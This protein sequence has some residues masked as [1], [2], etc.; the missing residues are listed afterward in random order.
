MRWYK[1]LASGF[2]LIY[3]PESL[4]DAVISRIGNADFTLDEITDDP[5]FVDYPGMCLVD[6]KTW[7]AKLSSGHVIEMPITDFHSFLH[8]VN[9]IA[10]STHAGVTYYR[11]FGHLAVV[12]MTSEMVSELRGL[13]ARDKL[14]IEKE[15]ALETERLNK[16]LAPLK[17][18]QSRR[19]RKSVRW[20]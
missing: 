5:A 16:R 7:T 11:L 6:R 17:N 12:A 18:V 13:M 19:Q 10:R 9:D 4:R 8:Q 14:M 2:K 1:V 15:A 20:N 3:Y